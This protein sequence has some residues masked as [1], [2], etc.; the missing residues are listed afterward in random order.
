M[1]SDGESL[2]GLKTILLVE[3]DRLLSKAISHD[4]ELKALMP[5]VGT[6]TLTVFIIYINDIFENTKKQIRLFADDS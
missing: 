1:V 3:H 5:G 4:Q 2:D 6:M